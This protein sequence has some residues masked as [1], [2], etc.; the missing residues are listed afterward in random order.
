MDE[1]QIVAIQESERLRLEERKTRRRLK[2][3]QRS[4]EEVAKYNAYQQEWRLKNKA[5]TLAYA[6]QW[7][8]AHPDQVKENNRNYI[9]THKEEKYLYNKQY[10]EEHKEAVKQYQ[11]QYHEAN[12][13][14]LLEQ[15]KIGS[16]FTRQTERLQVFEH[17]G[18]I[19][20]CCGNNRFETLTID[21]IDGKGIEQRR[22]LNNPGGVHFYHWLIENN[23]PEGYQTLCNPCN[24]LKAKHRFCLHQISGYILKDGSTVLLKND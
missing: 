23:F 12:R 17:Y 13:E 8:E 6:K 24:N 2:Y 21:H 9:N 4:P 3:A 5:K 22:E 15:N 16:N 10:V 20:A 14:T 1:E 11:Q 19:C 18:M 7:R